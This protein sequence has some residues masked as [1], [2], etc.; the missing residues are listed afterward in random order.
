MFPYQFW[1]F[2]RFFFLL[3]RLNFRVYIE[4][5]IDLNI[6][7]DSIPNQ[8]ERF[9]TDITSHTLLDNLV[10]GV[11]RKITDQDKNVLI[12]L[13]QGKNQQETAAMLDISQAAVS[14]HLKK[15]RI[16]LKKGL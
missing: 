8:P 7:K 16:F 9:N 3:I 12:L 10:P 5:F 6:T 1:N 13:A 11:S 4:R 15:I 2:L 14:K